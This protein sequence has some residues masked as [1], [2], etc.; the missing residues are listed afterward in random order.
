MCIVV[1]MSCK[2]VLLL[3]VMPNPESQEEVTNKNTWK[4]WFLIMVVFN[5][6][7]LLVYAGAVIAFAPLLDAEFTLFSTAPI[8]AWIFPIFGITLAL[9]VLYVIHSELE[10]DVAEWIIQVFGVIYGLCVGV[11]VGYGIWT[12]VTHC[13]SSADTI[14]AYCYDGTSLT[15]QFELVFW[16]LVVH[17]VEHFV[18][19]LFAWYTVTRRQ[20]LTPV[21]EKIITTTKAAYVPLQERNFYK[22]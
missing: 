1:Q 14:Y 15:L 18:M 12:W 5:V 3:F 9:L 16:L 13:K 17:F 8:Y 10:R 19:T 4:T 20:V 11:V 21:H 7:T 6:L 22:N 2:L